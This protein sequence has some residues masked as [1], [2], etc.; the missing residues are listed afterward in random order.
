MVISDCILYYYKAPYGGSL[1]K[2]LHE[3]VIF[4]QLQKDCKP[5]LPLTGISLPAKH[6]TFQTNII[7]TLVLHMM[8]AV[9]FIQPEVAAANLLN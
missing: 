5:V 8:A 4:Y 7:Q 2:D 1:T 3:D 9:L 6:D